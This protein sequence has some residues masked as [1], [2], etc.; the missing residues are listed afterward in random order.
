MKHC[1]RV[2]HEVPTI[3]LVKHVQRGNFPMMLYGI[4]KT[5][6]GRRHGKDLVQLSTLHTVGQEGETY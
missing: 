3:R 2:K 4:A 5:L 6:L 1:Q